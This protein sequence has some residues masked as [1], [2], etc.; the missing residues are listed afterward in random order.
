MNATLK[1]GTKYRTMANLGVLSD[2]VILNT[3]SKVELFALSETDDD[4]GLNTY[5][6]DGVT[7]YVRNADEVKKG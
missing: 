5:V 2:F 3:D 1:A 4:S 6:L 7:I